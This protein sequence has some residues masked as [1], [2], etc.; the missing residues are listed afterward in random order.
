MFNYVFSYHLD[1]EQFTYSFWFLILL[2]IIVS[3]TIQGFI[4]NKP[5]GVEN[6]PLF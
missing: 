4:L 1:T 5:G 6:Y 3:Y 2:N